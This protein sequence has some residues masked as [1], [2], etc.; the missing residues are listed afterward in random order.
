MRFAAG[1]L[2]FALYEPG[3]TNTNLREQVAAF[4]RRV[5]ETIEGSE[6]KAALPPANNPKFLPP[7][8][9]KSIVFTVSEIC[10]TVMV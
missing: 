8:L 3:S 1:A 6:A 4:V 5:L 7:K 10:E 9:K 2:G